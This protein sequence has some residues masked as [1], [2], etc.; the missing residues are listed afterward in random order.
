MGKSKDQ[1]LHLRESRKAQRRYDVQDV[2]NSEITL[3]P[4]D[5]RKCGSQE[6]TFHQYV[7]DAY[8]SDCGV[9]QLD[10]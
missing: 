1:F 7:G 8:C 5:C 10:N 6:V 3:Q 4:L 2:I 9:W